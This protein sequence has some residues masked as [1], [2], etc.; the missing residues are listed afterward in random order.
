MTACVLEILRRIRY[1]FRRDGLDAELREEMET[2]LAMLA[3]E[4][5]STYARQRIGNLTRWQEMSRE[6]W[7]WNWL[8]SLARDVGYGARLMVK[9][10]GFTLTACLSLAIGIGA[11]MGVF[12]LMNALLFKALP[13][14]EPRQLW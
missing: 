11:T 5:D 12:S 6:V 14:P 7:G 3:K 13:V 10:P 4:H 1:F 8:E 9:S 2:H